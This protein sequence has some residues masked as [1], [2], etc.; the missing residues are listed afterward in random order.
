MSL[1]PYSFKGGIHPPDS[2]GLSEEKAITAAKVPTLLTI[3]LVQH[4]GAPCKSAVEVGQAVKKG[5]ILG[6]A[7]GF[8]SAPVHAPVSGKVT[9]LGEVQHIT[10]KTVPAITIENDNLETWTDCKECP[11][12]S[13][14]KTQEIV[15]RI[16]AAGIVGMGGATFPTHVKLSPPKGKTIDTLI[17]NGVECEPYLTA[18]YRL[19]LEK[20][21]EIIEGSRILMK[22]LGVKK[23]FIGIEANKPKAIEVMKKALSGDT[24]LSVVTLNVKYPQGAEKM[25]IKAIVNREVPP[26]ALP[27]DVGVVVQNVAT[28]VAVYDAV[29]Y[30]RP[31]VERVVTVTG[32]AIMEPKNLLVRMGTSVAD[33]VTECGGFAVVPAKLIMGGPMMGF[34]LYSANTPVTKG[35]SGIIV[36]SANSAAS[37]DEF[38]PC[39]KCGRCI[40]ACP[41]GLMPSMLGVLSEKGFYEET[42]EYNVH[43][44]F[45]CGS[46][47]YVCPSK[48]PMVQ[49]I[50]LAKSL[51]KP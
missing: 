10:G 16:L 3:P 19:M 17:I 13:A 37:S 43:D 6:T 9:A 30:G 36:L 50:K 14:L 46:C 4:I 28:A 33:L 1:A 45:E 26:R 42:R 44:C 41:M 31:L 32:D 39:F 48:R 23:G 27:L 47:T 51:V 15:E 38:S 49:F 5:A 7:G 40:D 25:L 2:K 21:G 20:S 34:A 35:T 22:A 18:D 29:R 12:Y 11:D 24:S 8:V